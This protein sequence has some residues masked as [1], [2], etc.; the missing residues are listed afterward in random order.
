MTEPDP[1]DGAVKAASISFK[2][3]PT[4]TT[5]TGVLTETP[6]LIQSRDFNTGEPAF[7]PASPGQEPNAKMSVV[8]NFDVNG[9]PRSLWAQKPSAMFVAIAEAQKAAGCK[10]E[11]GCELSVRFSGEKAH[12]DPEK[13]RKGLPAQKLYEAKIKPA[14]AKPAPDAF[15]GADD[16]EPPW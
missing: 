3:A 4:G 10:L 12:T 6:K 16:K 1:F 8:I 11:P 2:D 9:E 15:A 7:W 5:F 14:P 13:V